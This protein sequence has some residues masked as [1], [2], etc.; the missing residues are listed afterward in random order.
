M[1]IAFT[2]T[3]I[4]FNT[5]SFYFNISPMR[6]S[7]FGAGNQALAGIFTPNFGTF[8]PQIG[9]IGHNGYT[10]ASRE[11]VS[12]Y[13]E[14]GIQEISVVD[15]PLQNAVIRL[16]LDIGSQLYDYTNGAITASTAGTIWCLAR[17]N[18]SGVLTVT[19]T[20]RRFYRTTFVSGLQT[21]DRL[22]VETSDSAGNACLPVNV[23]NV[24]YLKFRKANITHG[25]RYE[26]YTH[27]TTH[28]LSTFER[29][30]NLATI[31]SFVGHGNGIYN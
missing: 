6:Y 28:V 25:D 15:Y 20:R 19:N 3:G 4:N 26:T 18:S 11:S 9:T 5:S 2:G 7:L 16:K 8:I 10:Y 1:A 30:A 17:W 27:V 22:S 13:D 12:L 31:R 24:L 29:G 23:S 14:T 21:L